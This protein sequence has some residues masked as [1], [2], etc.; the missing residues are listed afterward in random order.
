M[1]RPSHYS[2]DRCATVHA[3]NDGMFNTT[4]GT[5][6]TMGT[7]MPKLCFIRESAMF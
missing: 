1:S 5:M 6:G 7:A 2:Y 4:Y 3:T